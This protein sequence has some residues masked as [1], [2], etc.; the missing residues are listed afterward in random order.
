MFGF[1]DIVFE[2][3][4]AFPRLLQREAETDADIVLGLFPTDRP[5][6]VDMVR[7]DRGRV[8]DFVIRPAHTDLSLC[9]AIAIWTPT[10]THFLHEHLK[11][12]RASAATSPELSVGHVIQAAVQAGLRVDG[13]PVSETPFYDIGTPDGL[14]RALKDWQ[15]VFSNSSPSLLARALM[16]RA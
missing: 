3:D 11:A 13:V 16:T 8:C 7:L 15:H 5:D 2:G 1:P 10:F 14:A 6:T 4:S 12:H 9:W